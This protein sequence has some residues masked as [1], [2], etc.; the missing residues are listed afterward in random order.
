MRLTKP[1]LE[2]LKKLYC[3]S[4]IRQYLQVPPSTSR[5]TMVIA[6]EQYKSFLSFRRSVTGGFY[7]NDTTV[8]ILWCGMTIG[9]ETDGYTHS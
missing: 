8:F 3:Q 9:I 7:C 6:K 5:N 2:A 4:S 1:Q